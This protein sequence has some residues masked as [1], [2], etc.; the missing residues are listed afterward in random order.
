M[1]I[2][3]LTFNQTKTEKTNDVWNILF[4]KGIFS[5][6]KGEFFQIF[7]RGE[8]PFTGCNNSLDKSLLLL[9]IE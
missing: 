7:K 2:C 8:V 3:M 5:L 1:R 6:K 4:K 9:Y